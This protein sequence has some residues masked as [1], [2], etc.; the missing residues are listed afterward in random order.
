MGSLLWAAT[1]VAQP[2][3]TLPNPRLNYLFPAGGQVGT[4]F[5]VTITGDDLDDARQL[6]FSHAGITA[7]LTMADPGLARPVPNPLYGTFQVRIAPDVPPG[8]YELRALGKFGLSNPRAFAVGTLP[9]IRETEPNNVPEAGQPGRTWNN[10]QW[11]MR[12]ARTGLFQVLGQE[13]TAGHH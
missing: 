10:D 12:R 13:R 7:K 1:A 9:E 5:D 11:H 2:P 6:V 3:P 4:T 8:V